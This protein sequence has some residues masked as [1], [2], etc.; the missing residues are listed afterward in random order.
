MSRQELAEAVNAYAYEHAGRRVTVDARYVG[1]LERGEHRWP[2]EPCR[3]A[4]RKV[5]G[6]ATNAELGFFVIHGHAKDPDVSPA[7]PETL[8]GMSVPAPDDT[9]GAAAAGKV[10]GDEGGGLV[11]PGGAAT[12]RVS[13]TVEAAQV[14]VV[15]EEG[16]AGRVAVLAGPVEVLIEPCDSATIL[17][18]VPARPGPAADEPG[19]RRP[20]E[21]RQQR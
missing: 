5:L 11:I 2:F 3:T 14:R 20:T 9:G 13:L 4:L 1:K 8:S 21:G 7:S 10:V 17:T 6:K 18:P 15:R 16:P 12:V 19:A